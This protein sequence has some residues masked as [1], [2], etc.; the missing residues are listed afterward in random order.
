MNREHISRGLSSLVAATSSSSLCV[1][2]DCLHRY[3][4][5]FADYCWKFYDSQPVVLYCCLLCNYR[6]IP[7]IYTDIVMVVTL[8]ANRDVILYQYSETTM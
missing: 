2:I 8:I 6:M 7:W 1:M 4:I 5:D 3:F